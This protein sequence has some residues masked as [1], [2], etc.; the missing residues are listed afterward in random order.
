MKEF[1]VYLLLSIAGW[2]MACCILMSF[3]EFFV[4]RFLM[5]K[6]LLPNFLYKCI[7]GFTT[8]FQNHHVLHHGRFYKVFNHEVDPQGRVIS[9][10]LDLWIAL[11][12]GG[13]IW[14]LTF[15]LTRVF[16]PVLTSVAFLHHLAWNCI[17][18]EMHNPRPRWFARTRFFKFFAH[19]HWMHHRYPG[20]NFNVV[21]P[22]ADFILGKYRKPNK[23]DVAQMDAIG[24]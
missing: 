3:I 1:D 8:V 14:A 17:H 5:H 6:R 15:P 2:F 21:F 22:F 4:H 24:I 11:V 19:Y 12:G 13:L 18:E 20:K 10:R 16:G 7:P 9:I 23:E